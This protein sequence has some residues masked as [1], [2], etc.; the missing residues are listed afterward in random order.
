M[1]LIFAVAAAAGTGIY[2]SIHS[3]A[4]ER[5]RDR[6]ESATLS[7]TI[8]G[9]V[10]LDYN[11][12][13]LY[14]TTGGTADAPTAVDGWRCGVTVT[15]YDA[16]GVARGSATSAPMVRTASLRPEQAL[17]GSNSRPF[18]AATRRQHEVE[19]RAR[20]MLH[21]QLRHRTPERPCS[22]SPTVR[23]RT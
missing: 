22:S 2:L 1:L 19:L 4:Q 12:D 6:T 7:G 11:G 10:F 16:A 23:T 18:R 3:D 20:E 17:I 8:S 13:A 9:R 15:L 5:D 21:C 14:E